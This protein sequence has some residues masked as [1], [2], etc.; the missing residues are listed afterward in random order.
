MSKGFCVMFQ[1]F[2]KFEGNFCYKYNCLVIFEPQVNNFCKPVWYWKPTRCPN[3]E[4]L[5]LVLTSCR[6]LRLYMFCWLGEGCVSRGVLLEQL[7]VYGVLGLLLRAICFFYNQSESCVGLCQGFYLT[8]LF[9]MLMD[10]ISRHRQSSGS[11]DFI[12]PS[13]LSRHGSRLQPSVKLPR[14]E[15]V[16]IPALTD[17]H[18]L[19]IVSETKRRVHVC[20]LK[21]QWESPT[22]GD[23]KHCS[24]EVRLH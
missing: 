14:W 15:S 12:K 2:V 23:G 18:E 22:R 20:G 6:P 19:W 9:V 24:G 11:V 21:C 16:H 1:L 5:I 8:T 3:S 7:P 13:N 17:V 10:R 4:H